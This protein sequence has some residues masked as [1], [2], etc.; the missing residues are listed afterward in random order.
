MA[1]NEH[2]QSIGIP[3]A[4]ARIRQSSRVFQQIIGTGGPPSSPGKRPPLG[5]WGARIRLRSSQRVRGKAPNPSPLARRSAP[6]PS[7]RRV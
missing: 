5:F 2:E 1:V 3:K 6:S 7:V 4:I